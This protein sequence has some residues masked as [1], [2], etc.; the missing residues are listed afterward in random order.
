M[1]CF[2]LVMSLLIR[3]DFSQVSEAGVRRSF[4]E[5]VGCFKV[6]RDGAYHKVVTRKGGGGR[7][8]VSHGLRISYLR[9]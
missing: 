4:Y 8:R 2:L 7:E 6:K 9:T 5:W 1:P 3:W